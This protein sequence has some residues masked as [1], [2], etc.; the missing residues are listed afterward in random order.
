MGSQEN[1]FSTSELTLR[2]VD[3]RIKQA[4]DPVLRQ[5]EELFFLLTNRTE[6]ES[7]GNSETSDSRRDNTSAS[8]SGSRYEIR[9]GAGKT[10]DEKTV[11]FMLYLCYQIVNRAGWFFEGSFSEEYEFNL[12]ADFQPFYRGIVTVSSINN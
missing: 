7:A 12:F 4:T 10:F 1:E 9:I 3:E 11:M 2:S 5:V 8:P 6:L